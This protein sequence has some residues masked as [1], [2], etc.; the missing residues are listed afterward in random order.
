MHKNTILIVIVLLIINPTTILAQSFQANISISNYG[1]GA[2]IQTPR[3][4]GWSLYVN[5]SIRGNR[6]TTRTA[7]RYYTDLNKR[8]YYGSLSYVNKWRNSY[9]SKEF[10]IGMGKEIELSAHSK[11]NIEGGYSSAIPGNIYYIMSFNI[12]WSD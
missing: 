11:I 8:S 3:R 9:H 4:E 10:D 2:G 7:L 5:T 6:R 12:N 1:Y